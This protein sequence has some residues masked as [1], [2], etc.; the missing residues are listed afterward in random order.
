MK[1]KNSVQ[2]TYHR[3]FIYIYK[4]GALGASVRPLLLFLHGL[5]VRLSSNDSGGGGAQTCSREKFFWKISTTSHRRP[6]SAGLFCVCERNASILLKTIFR[7]CHLV[8]PLSR[9]PFFVGILLSPFFFLPFHT[10]THTLTN[11]SDQS[12]TTPPTTMSQWTV[13]LFSFIFFFNFNP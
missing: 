1:E 6:Q 8:L 7:H 12:L 3:L 10:R 11:T 2:K 5:Y 9:F 13:F 4:Y